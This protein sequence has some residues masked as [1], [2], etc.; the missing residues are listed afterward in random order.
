MP[1]ATI[2]P[3]RR[4]HR[5]Q[6]VGGFGRDRAM[7]GMH[8]MSFRILRPDRQEGAGPDVKRHEMLG[9]AVIGERAEQSVGEM[10]P[11]GRRGD[12]ALL[13]REHRLVVA[14]VLRV[15]VTARGDV[16]RERHVAQAVD[17]L[18]ES[19]AGEIEDK[20]RFAFVPARGDGR[21]EAA[22]E[23]RRRFLRRTRMRSPALSRFAGRAKACQR[24]GPSLSI[25]VTATLAA[26]SSRLRTPSSSAGMTLVSLKTSASPGASSAGRSSTIRSAIGGVARGSTRR[27]RAA[28]RGTTGRSAISSSGR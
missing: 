20:R 1:T 23:T 4:L 25:S 7:L 2:R 26:P 17:R 8:A 9:N 19:G 12:R 10:K 11:G 28:S 5:V 15:G 18:V 13:A 3:P 16:R 6:G 27:S 24:S 22:G 21:G 14:A